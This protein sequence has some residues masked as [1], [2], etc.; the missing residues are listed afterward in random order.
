M[1]EA[2]TIVNKKTCK[3][4]KADKAPGAY[5][6]LTT[7]IMNYWISEYIYNKLDLHRISVKLK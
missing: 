1:G 7:V 5:L 4:L 2:G 6:E 3:Y